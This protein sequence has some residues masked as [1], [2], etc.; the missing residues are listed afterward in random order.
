M[1]KLALSSLA[2][3]GLAGSL[4]AHAQIPTA[5]LGDVVPTTDA[6][7]TIE[8]TSSTHWVNVNAGEVVRFV[9]NGKEFAFNFD[10]R[11]VSSFDLARVAPE[12]TLDHSV[13]AYVEPMV[14]GD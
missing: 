14:D 2:A 3:L 6:V 13:T 8:I 11:D 5:L 10:S 4:V 9:V 12:G 7:R 1:K